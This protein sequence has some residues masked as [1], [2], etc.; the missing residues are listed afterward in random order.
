M[1]ISTFF[2][3]CC[4]FFTVLI[5][6]LFAGATT[7]VSAADLELEGNILN[8]GDTDWEDIF[9]VSGD[10]VPTEANPLPAGYVQSVFVRDFVPG[11][12]G[13]DISTFATGSKDT[14][15][16]TPGWECTRSNNVNDKTDIV[17]AYAT[18]SSNGDIVVYFGMERYS[19]DGTGNI[20]FWFLKDGSTGC[21]VQANGPKT[22]PFTGNH[23]DG[24]ILI[25]AEFD[26]G[27]ASVTIAAYRWMGNAA[28]FLDP[29]P[30]AAG[31]QCVGGGGAQNLCAIVNTNVL[32]G[33]GAATDVPWLTE[34]KQPGNTPSND[35]AVSEFFEGKI[36]LTALDLVGCF[37][38]Y[39]AVTRSSTSLT[40][41]IFD[42][43][44]GDFS[45]CSIDVTKACTTGIDN[46]V[47]N[48]AGDKV[49]TT[50]DV[51]VTNDGAGSVSDVTIE[52]DIT[53]GT[54]ESCELIAIDGDATGLPIDI[55]D[56]A[57][58]EVAATLA[59]DASVVARVRCET[60]DNPLD[61]MV[62]ARAK[63]VGSAGT[64]DLAES[65]DMT[66]QQLCP[67]AVS[68]MIDVNKTCTD[69]RLTT[70]SGILTMEVEVDVTLQNT[71]DEKLVNVLISNVVGDTAG[72]TPIALQHVAADGETPLPAFDGELAPGETVYF[73]SVYI[74]T[75]VKN[76]GTDP[77]TATF[78]DRVD[79]SGVGA[80]S[81]ASA[82]DFSTAE[83][84]LCPP[85]EE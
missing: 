10:N 83:C 37:T 1:E 12:S 38:K 8:D 17:N 65:Y 46:P 3:K 5:L 24:D 49:I 45:L 66:A 77:S 35:L 63:S 59:K 6:V 70:S 56:G 55:S 21:P 67:L 28:G 71:S 15:N 2:R 78:E 48:A 53:L 80:I 79:A 81:G 34:T 30:I 16:I 60:N 62:T 68:P 82:T 31:G 50:F 20:G 64:P 47:I 61:N 41:T 40:A 51:T 44:L 58:Y 14:L 42:F 76:G 11:A 22:L 4:R 39:M 19:N 72:G 85:H 75:V 52:E 27:G 18:A 23:S 74:P 25:V 57:A 7:L 84:P 9:D 69:V 36:N 33:Y 43:A 26:N 54:G 29:T 73:E 13:P 32:N